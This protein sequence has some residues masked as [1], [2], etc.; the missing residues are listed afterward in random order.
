MKCSVDERVEVVEQTLAAFEMSLDL[1]DLL[2]AGPC[3]TTPT[4]TRSRPRRTTPKA[5]CST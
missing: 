1:D 4:S 5:P 2:A 3:R